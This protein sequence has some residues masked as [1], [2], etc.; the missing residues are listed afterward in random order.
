M[1]TLT[2]ALR[3]RPAFVLTTLIFGIVGLVLFAGH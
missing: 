3:S 2:D 1:E